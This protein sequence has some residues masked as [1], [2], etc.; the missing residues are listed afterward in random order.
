MG[1]PKLNKSVASVLN[2]ELSETELL[3]KQLEDLNAQFQA[4]IAKTSTEKKLVQTPVNNDDEDETN[5][6]KI[7][8]DDYIKVMSLYPGIL[9]LTK[10]PKGKGIPF[11]FRK[12][13][14]V[15]RIL[16]RDLV[17]IM[18]VNPRFLDEGFYVILNNKVIRKH[19]LDDAYSKLL[20]KEK[21][22]QILA[23]ENQ[24]DA[25]NFFKAAN[26]SQKQNICNLIM[27]KLVNDEF[28]DLNLLDRISREMGKAL[29]DEDYNLAKKAEDARKLKEIK[30]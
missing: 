23:G 10:E 21:I 26:D 2:V 30:N 16:Y 12:F 17:N 14:E 20:T 15:K 6:I 29:G 4:Y 9:Y 1:R 19:G 28:I 11:I 5:E 7:S 3:K 22:D 24:T 27:Q 8:S 25:V 13:G 18:E